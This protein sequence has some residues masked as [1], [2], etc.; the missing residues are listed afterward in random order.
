MLTLYYITSREK[1]PLAG[2][3]LHKLHNQQL[4]VLPKQLNMTLLCT[5]SLALAFTLM[6]CAV[7]AGNS[8]NVNNKI[9]L[10]EYTG[11]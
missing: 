6:I 8:I 5:T 1:I 10:L 3:R 4:I 2:S 7:S 11:N 9:L